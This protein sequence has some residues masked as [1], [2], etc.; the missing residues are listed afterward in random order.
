M[1]AETMR[2][3]PGGLP[4]CLPE[5]GERFMMRR[6]LV[7]RVANNIRGRRRHGGGSGGAGAGAGAG[8]VSA[9][10]GAGRGDSAVVVVGE[11]RGGRIPQG[12]GES[13]HDSPDPRL[14]GHRRR[15]RPVE[16]GAVHLLHC[17]T[18]RK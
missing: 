2:G 13:R 11:M 14:G 17:V 10:S 12:R 7:Q 18:A 3:L 6:R 5:R 9:G 15:V 16:L 4:F 1:V 8:R